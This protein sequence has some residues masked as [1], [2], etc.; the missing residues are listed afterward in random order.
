[1]PECPT[2]AKK[3]FRSK[4]AACR[5]QRRNYNGPGKDRL[6]PYECVCGSWHLT[7]QTP[8]EQARIAA[9]VQAAR[10]RTVLRI[11]CPRG[12]D[13]SISVVRPDLEPLPQVPDPDRRSPYPNPQERAWFERTGQAVCEALLAHALFECTAFQA[14]DR[15]CGHQ[16]GAYQC[17]LSAGHH[18][19]HEVLE[20]I[21]AEDRTVTVAWW[22]NLQAVQ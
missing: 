16:Q 20:Y 19:R 22:P 7:H 1:M 2:P 3:A 12:C 18:G 5:F 4:A 13:Q 14:E 9:R 6:W 21:E 11:V 15:D 17:N 8:A 10:P